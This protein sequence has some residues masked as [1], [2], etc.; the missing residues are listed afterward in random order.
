MSLECSTFSSRPTAV[1]SL[2]SN[3]LLV[4]VSSPLLAKSGHLSPDQA[5]DV[6]FQVCEG[7]EYAH[8][9]DIL[10]RDLKPSNIML[11]E[12]GGLSE[13]VKLVD[14]GVAR[15]LSDDSDD[16]K[17]SGYITRTR[18]VF[19][20]PMYMSPEQCMGKK[21]DGRSD[22]YSLGCVM[23][24]TLTGK[25]PFVGKNVL[26]TAYKHMNELPKTF[27]SD[28]P[29]DRIMARLEAVIFKCLAKDPNDR[30]Q[31]IPQLRS[32]LQSLPV[33]SEVDWQATSYAV[34]K[35]AKSKKKNKEKGA[36]ASGKNRS[37]PLKLLFLS[38]LHC[39][40]PS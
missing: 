20:S 31:S 19:G 18:E 6:F 25:P 29:A 15:L 22:M 4:K 35:Q 16:S 12:T 27:A 17:N 5:I 34:Q 1:F 40:S 11:V 3:N 2:L 26:E 38:W 10:H 30:Y 13:E 28:R 23:Y 7:L 24:E 9:Q 39:F 33:A 32:D 37:S 36:E 21:L 8:E 14:F